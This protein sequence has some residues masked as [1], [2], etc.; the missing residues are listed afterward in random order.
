LLVMLVPELA[1][2]LLVTL[3]LELNVALLVLLAPVLTL[4][5]LVNLIPPV[6]LTVYLALD[7]DPSLNPSHFVEL[8][9]YSVQAQPLELSLALELFGSGAESS[10]V[11]NSRSDSIS[12]RDCDSVC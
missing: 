7:V 4:V 2:A 8:S 5:L 9:L 11:D 3:V 6:D 10:L 1:V 12:V